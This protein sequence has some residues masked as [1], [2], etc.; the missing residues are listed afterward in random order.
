M[1]ARAAAGMVGA[2]VAATGAEANL[3]QDTKVQIAQKLYH[4]ALCI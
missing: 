1:A 3:L 4:S 2:R